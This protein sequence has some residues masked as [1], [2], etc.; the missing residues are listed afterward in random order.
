M[1]FVHTV[2]RGLLFTA[3]VVF[4]ATVAFVAAVPH[5]YAVE[6]VDVPLA[7]SVV[8]PHGASVR[9][10]LREGVPPWRPHWSGR[11][12]VAVIV[13][14][15]DGRVVAPAV[16]SRASLELNTAGAFWTPDDHVALTRLQLEWRLPAADAARPGN[17]ARFETSR[18]APRA[19]MVMAVGLLSTLGLWL[20]GVV[21]R[22]TTTG[23][24][25][26]DDVA[27]AMAP[28]VACA[29][30]GGAAGLRLLTP[31]WR[32]N[33]TDAGTIASLAAATA[34]PAAFLGDAMMADP[35]HYSWYTG[36]YI[37]GVVAVR[38]YGLEADHAFAVVVFLSVLLGV[39]GYTR[40]LRVVSGRASWALL[41]AVTITAFSLG[42]PA[43]E[44]WAFGQALPRSL[45]AGVLPWCVLLAIHVVRRPLLWPMLGLAIGATT[46]VHP[47]SAPA[48][49]GA[50]GLLLVVTKRREWARHTLALAG[51]AIGAVVALAPFAVRFLG[52][53]GNRLAAGEVEFM[54]VP[55]FLTVVAP[56]TVFADL[57]TT[58]LLVLRLAACAAVLWSV[59][60][61]YPSAVRMSVA[62]V[63][64]L[65]V[66]CLVVPGVDWWWASRQGVMPQQIELTRGVR[67]L[68]VVLMV[69][70]ALFA[71]LAHRERRL[72]PVLAGVFVL[73][74]ALPILHTA[75]GT[76][77]AAA[78]ATRASQGRLIPVAEARLEM[79]H[80]LDATRPEFQRVWVP[81]DLDFL[82]AYEI[83]L[84]FT[85]KDPWGLSIV[86]V[87]AM[88]QA[89][90]LDALATE[91]ARAG[92]DQ[93][94]AGQLLDA[95]GATFLVL[96]R[97]TVRPELLVSGWVRFANERYVV[98]RRT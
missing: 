37:K 88:Q 22:L 34:N 79:L 11:P 73:L 96:Y 24:P 74:Y 27:M 29:M 95:S 66:V 16:L 64:G 58:P 85:W 19:H 18:E 48:V 6:V 15:L 13:N 43:N 68:E 35:A 7:S 60:R 21:L 59:R 8:E 36:L 75:T 42:Y 41:G 78:A 2:S 40:L 90:R 26:V 44:Q 50:V 4:G 98:V 65:C 81:F 20:A 23:R 82:R 31:L 57:V 97:V 30:A 10:V 45:F 14:T 72:V 5:L 86:D 32:S 70:L 28:I 47:V 69:A 80:F 1:A 54:V 56:V 89:V 84:A 93:A 77:K 46:Y 61:R 49:I 87:P 62:A 67:Y 91:L 51:F 3:A 9:G 12:P 25:R 63:L 17:V 33:D 92:F 71:R 83:P 53:T 52:F 39:V 76:G 55:A 94:A 38:S